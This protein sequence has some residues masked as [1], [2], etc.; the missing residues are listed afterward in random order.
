M[1]IWLFKWLFGY[2]RKSLF[3]TAAQQQQSIQ[4]IRNSNNELSQVDNPKHTKLITTSAILAH[5][6]RCHSAYRVHNVVDGRTLF[7]IILF[8]GLNN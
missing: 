8:A 6:M 7:F 3:L 2:V 1:S 4:S 5:Y